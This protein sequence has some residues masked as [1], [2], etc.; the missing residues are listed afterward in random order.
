[1]GGGD[2]VCAGTAPRD[3]DLALDALGLEL[4]VAVPSDATVQ[5]VAQAMLRAG[6]SAV[7]VGSWTVVTERDVARAVALGRSPTT[8]AAAIAGQASPV[9][10]GHTKVVKALATMLSEQMTEVV[11]IDNDM[12]VIGML[13]LGTAVELALRDADAPSSVAAL[14]EALGLELHLE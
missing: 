14:R 7:V 12:Q 8:P 11:V 13:D 9:V 5:T 2:S 3:D 4:P 1:M 10:S 6:R